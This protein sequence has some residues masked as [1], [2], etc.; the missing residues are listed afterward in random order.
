MHHWG[1]KKG[2]LPLFSFILLT[3]FRMDR[4]S[5]KFFL[6]MCY[7]KKCKRRNE[8]VKKKENEK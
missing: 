8:I 2:I 4:H 3:L 6:Y 7:T 1:W 5:W